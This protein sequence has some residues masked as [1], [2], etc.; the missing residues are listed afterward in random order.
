MEKYC[1]VGQVTDDNIVHARWTLDTQGYKYRLR[2]CNS[3]CFSTTKMVAQTRLKVTLI[4]TMV[5][6]FTYCLCTELSIL[7]FG[8]S[9]WT[10]SAALPLQVLAGS[11]RELLETVW[12]LWLRESVLHFSAIE[13]QSSLPLSHWIDRSFTVHRNTS[14][15]YRSLAIIYVMLRWQSVTSKW[16][17]LTLIRIT[18]YV[19]QVLHPNSMSLPGDRVRDNKGKALLLRNVGLSNLCISFQNKLTSPSYLDV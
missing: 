1:R 2:I 12:T 3:Y 14:G 13:T 4:C 18:S 11:P 19:F 5:G 7:I 8:T 16:V 10:I 9:R 15:W 6:L 17:L